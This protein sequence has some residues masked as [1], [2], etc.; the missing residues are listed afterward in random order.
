[1]LERMHGR[2]HLLQTCLIE[3]NTKLRN[4]T[5]Q[6]KQKSGGGLY[7]IFMVYDTQMRRILEE[8][9]YSYIPQLSV[10]SFSIFSEVQ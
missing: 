4:K 3:N 9:N 7:T 10:L 1:M 8:V 5:K 2:L 6:K